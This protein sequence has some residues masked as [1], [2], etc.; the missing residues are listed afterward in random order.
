[1]YPQCQTLG[2]LR[3]SQGLLP[4]VQL[5]P[6]DCFGT[7]YMGPITPVAERGARRMVSGVDYMSR[8]SVARAVP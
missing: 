6:W 2:P 1:M 7:D 4:I 3:L 5:Q 8:V